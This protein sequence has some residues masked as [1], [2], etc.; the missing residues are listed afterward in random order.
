MC[1]YTSYKQM[2]NSYRV[3]LYISCDTELLPL[4]MNCVLQRTLCSWYKYIKSYVLISNCH[5]Y[6]PYMKIIKSGP[7]WDLVFSSCKEWG[8]SP[9]SMIPGPQEHIV[10]AP[11]EPG[12]P[13]ETHNGGYMSEVTRHNRNQM[14]K[15]RNVPFTQPLMGRIDNDGRRYG[16]LTLCAQLCYRHNAG[17][18]NNNVCIC[19][20]QS[21]Q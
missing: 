18:R 10:H 13:D 6:N 8:T 7:K 17:C 4:C 15:S 21:K 12:S 20:I 11:V 16:S 5:L 3:K 9:S 19:H 2:L 1:L 14:C